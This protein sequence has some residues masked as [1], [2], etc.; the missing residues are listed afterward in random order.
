MFSMGSGNCHGSQMNGGANPSTVDVCGMP[1]M[2]M[3]Q[4]DPDDRSI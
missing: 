4:C 3:H 2:Q 1:L